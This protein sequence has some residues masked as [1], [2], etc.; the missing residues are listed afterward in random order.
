MVRL[1]KDSI[2]KAFSPNS[3]YVEALK[4]VGLDPE[5]EKQALLEIL[6]SNPFIGVK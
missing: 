4:K 1:D 5:K 2:E 3:K 6:G